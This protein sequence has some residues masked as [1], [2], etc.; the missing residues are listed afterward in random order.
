MNKSSEIKEENN[1]IID[2]QMIQESS[3]E[4]EFKKR[5]VKCNSIHFFC[6][7]HFLKQL[8]DFT[9]LKFMEKNAQ[10]IYRQHTKAM[11]EMD[12]KFFV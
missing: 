3:I 10:Y 7:T 1:S 5:S 4:A 8:A 6:F 9:E 12:F 11:H 2:S